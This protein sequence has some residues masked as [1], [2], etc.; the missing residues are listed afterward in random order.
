MAAAIRNHIQKLEGILKGYVY[1]GP[2]TPFWSLLEQKTKLKRERI[3]LGLLGFIA[4]YLVLGWAKDFVCNFIGFIYPA[5]ASVLAVESAVTHDDTEWLIYWIVYASFGF[6]EYIGYTFFHSLPFYWL[7][8]CVLLIWLMMPGEKGGSHFLYHRFIRPFVLK[9][10]PAIDKH[11]KDGDD[12]STD[13]YR[14]SRLIQ[15]LNLQNSIDQ[16]N[17]NFIL[18]LETENK[19]DNKPY[20]IDCWSLQSG[21]CIIRNALNLSKIYYQQIST[22]EK[23]HAQKFLFNTDPTIPN[24]IFPFHFKFNKCNNTPTYLFLTSTL[25]KNFILSNQKEKSDDLTDRVYVQC[26]EQA[27]RRTI[28]LRAFVYDDGI[29]KLQNYVNKSTITKVKQRN[30]TVFKDSIMKQESVH[31]ENSMNKT[32]SSSHN[33]K[34]NLTSII[35]VSRTSSTNPMASDDYVTNKNNNTNNNKT[36]SF[37]NYIHEQIP[38]LNINDYCPEQLSVVRSIYTDFFEHESSDKFRLFQDIIYDENNSS[39]YLFTNQQ[40]V[41]KIIRL[42]EGQISFRHYVELQINCGNEYTLIQKVKLIKFNNNKQ[43][44]LTIAS[45]SKT[46]HSL[47]PSINS[48][49]AICLYELDQIRNAFIENILD[50]SKGNVSLGMAWL[51][52]ESVI[53]Q[54]PAPYGNLARCST[55]RDASYLMIYEG[56]SNIISQPIISFS[57]D[58]LTSLEATVINDYIVV[59]AG[60]ADGKIKKISVQPSTKKAFQ[61]EE[62]FV[63]FGD[64]ILRDMILDNNSRFLYGATKTRLFQV[65]LHNCD[66]YKTCFSCLSSQN[67]YCGWGTTLNRCTIRRN[68]TNDQRRFRW[69]QIYESCPSIIEMRPAFISK[70]KSDKLHLQVDNVPDDSTSKYFCS[71]GLTSLLTDTED[72]NNNDKPIYISNA[73]KYENYIICYSPPS[74]TLLNINHGIHN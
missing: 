65:D 18:Y 57:S 40:Y 34:S 54:Y 58:Q 11:I 9:H 46:L 71:F 4:I 69:L 37:F 68:E 72:N 1:E 14:R 19:I 52:G 13:R 15:S 39:I 27:Q 22:N 28:A 35:G 5:Y 12:V 36:S 45:K 29:R 59:L 30:I 16:N 7:G 44:L 6:A 70:A 21:S 62:I 32:R 26:L 56:S 43:Y 38:F 50:L 67:P 25:R 66:R 31:I 49:S 53:P 74:E 61:F 55:T 73:I 23:N 8:K 10:H 20:L 33:N 42:C 60:T 3:A 63:H 48:H 51:H 2:L 64:S 24:H 41:S 17:Y 47:E